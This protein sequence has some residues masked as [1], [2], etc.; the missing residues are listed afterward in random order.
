MKP[1]SEQATGPLGRALDL[2][3]RACML[4]AGVQIVLLIAVFGWLVFGRYILNDTPTW[5][6]QLALVLVAWIT[7]LGAAAG[8]W[9]R[10]HLSIEFVREA[11]PRVIGVPLHWLGVFGMIVFGACLAWQGWGLTTSTWSRSI[12][13]LGIAEGWRALPMAICGV[14]T[15]VFSAYH[16]AGLLPG[17]TVHQE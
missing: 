7:F 6:E 11:M 4:V 12:P 15:V 14:L 16:L 9:T 5:V 13:M 1:M 8:V 17:R 3:A 10:S 2:L